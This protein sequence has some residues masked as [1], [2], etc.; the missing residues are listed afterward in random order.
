MAKLELSKSGISGPWI[1]L[2]EN[3]SNVNYYILRVPNIEQNDNYIISVTVSDASSSEETSSDIAP[4]RITQTTDS[5]IMI[6]FLFIPGLSFLVLALA[7]KQ[8]LQILKNRTIKVIQ[9]KAEKY[10]T[11]HLSFKRIE[12]LLSTYHFNLEGENNG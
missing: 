6:G 7:R 8:V 5:Q 1:T 11:L 2:A 12:S 9:I 4:I 10:P 3:L